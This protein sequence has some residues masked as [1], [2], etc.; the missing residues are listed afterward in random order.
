MPIHCMLCVWLL[1][2]YNGRLSH[3]DGN[4]VAHNAKIFIIWP[5]TDPA[6]SGSEKMLCHYEFVRKLT[7]ISVDGGMWQ[8]SLHFTGNIVKAM[9]Y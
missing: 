3:C 9:I 2:H 4:P 1:S 8:R 5:F 7:Y 6:L